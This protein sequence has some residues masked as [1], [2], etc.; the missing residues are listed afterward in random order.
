MRVLSCDLI[1]AA[2]SISSEFWYS[3]WDK[4]KEEL[5]RVNTRDETD[6]DFHFHGI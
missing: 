3:Q 5:R 2:V 4:R 6:R 1:R